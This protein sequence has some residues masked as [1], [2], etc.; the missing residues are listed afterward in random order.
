MDVLHVIKKDNLTNTAEKHRIHLETMN[1]KQVH[2]KI[3]KWGK[4]NFG[5]DS[6]PT[7]R[8]QQMSLLAVFLI[9]TQGHPLSITLT[10]AL[11]TRKACSR[12]CK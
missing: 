7:T 10:S 3:H 2:G 9:S 12:K 5:H 8:K 6:R 11:H 4:R 1:T